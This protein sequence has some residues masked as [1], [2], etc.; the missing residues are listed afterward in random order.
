MEGIG[1]HTIGDLARADLN[2]LKAHL[3]DKYA[4][5]IHQ[6]ANGIDPDPVAE[7]NPVNKGYGNSIT[8]SQDVSDYETASQVILSLAETVGARLRADHVLCNSVCVELKDW[9]FRVQTHQA[10]LPFATDSTSVIYEKARSLLK[11]FWD[12]TPVRLIGVRTGK[13]AD[14]TYVQMSLF[15]D[16]QAEKRKNLEK[17]VDSIRSKYGT[18]SI[19]RASFLKKDAIVDHAAG[20]HKHLNPRGKEIFED[21]EDK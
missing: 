15:D 2:I 10:P 14:H 9:Q 7:R 19:K 12:L 18:D 21:N 6:Y 4:V 5:L 8:L 20:K 17:A 13:I 16:D 1:I 11:E 3:G